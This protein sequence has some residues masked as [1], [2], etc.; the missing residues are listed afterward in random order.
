M[1]TDQQMM[2]TS[3]TQPAD[4]EEDDQQVIGK[5]SLTL[6]EAFKG[7]VNDMLSQ[8]GM[9]GSTTSMGGHSDMLFICVGLHVTLMYGPVTQWST[10]CFS[11]DCQHV[12]SKVHHTLN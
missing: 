9:R 8:A 11:E 2:V 10:I 5:A 3:L 7:T 1:T 6:V 4:C 12:T